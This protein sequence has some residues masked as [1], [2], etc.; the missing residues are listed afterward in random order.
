MIFPGCSVTKMREASPGGAVMYVGAEKLP[1]FTSWTA[2]AGTAKVRRSSAVRH[3]ARLSTSGRLQM[4]DRVHAALVCAW[5]NGGTAAG[6]DHRGK[7]RAHGCARAGR[8]SA[9]LAPPGAA[10][11]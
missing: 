1:T 6:G 9:R 4:Y 7:P 11:H 8:R 10:L 3:P 2:P 5:R